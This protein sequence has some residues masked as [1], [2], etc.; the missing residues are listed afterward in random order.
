M[1]LKGNKVVLLIVII[2]LVTVSAVVLSIS[3][4]FQNNQVQNGSVLSIEG[5]VAIVDE[6]NILVIQGK[7]AAELKGLT[8]VEM[9]EGVNE[10]IWFSLSIDQLKRVNEFDTIRVTYSRVSETFPGRASANSVK[11]ISDDFSN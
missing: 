11:N 3:I 2:A 1:Q 8:E 9:L 5:V 10:A 6:P 7:D 4:F